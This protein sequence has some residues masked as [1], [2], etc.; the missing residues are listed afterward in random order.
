MINNQ[1]QTPMTRKGKLSLL[2]AG[3]V[4]SMAV[5][6]PTLAAA[7]TTPAAPIFDT[8]LAVIGHAPTLKKDGKVTA[9][10][11]NGDGMLGEGDT[12]KVSDFEFEDADSDKITSIDYEWFANNTSIQKSTSEE[13]TLEKKWLGKTITVTATAHTDPA[14]TEPAKSE[15]PVA[16][17]SYITIDKTSVTDGSGINMVSGSAVSSVKITGMSGS[18]PLVGETLKASVTCHGTCDNSKLT[19]QWQIEGS[20][21]VYGD[22][23]GGAT[24]TYTVKNTDQKKKI[25]VIVSNT[26]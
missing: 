23:K 8:T 15:K 10:D 20:T 18:Q 11:N 9:T 22:I 6:A 19:Y 13:L 17:K 14:T 21:G 12:L 4:L 5:S 24:S 1:Q 16:A 3:A 2:I 7:K 25:K 26:K